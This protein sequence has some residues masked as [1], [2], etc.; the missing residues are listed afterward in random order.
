MNE[1]FDEVVTA[2]FKEAVSEAVS[3]FGALSDGVES[4][5]ANVLRT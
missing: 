4:P 5:R 2:E 1:V 3:E